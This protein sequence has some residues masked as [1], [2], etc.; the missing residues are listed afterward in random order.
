LRDITA[1]V[2]G[3]GFGSLLTVAASYY[4]YRGEGSS[5]VVFLLD[6]LLLGVAIV[7][8]RVSF[9]MMNLVTSTRNKKSRRVLVYGAGG[10]GRLLV[11]E[12]RA[13]A[14]WRMNPVGFIDDDPM[15]AHRWIVGVPVH[16]ALDQLERVM[17]KYS[18]DEVLLSSPAINGSVEHRIREVCAQL[19]RPVRR[20]RMEIN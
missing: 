9:Q 2:R 15:K 18:V 1:V 4:L 3:V 7:L 6:A 12:M 20:L 13:N 14:R 8:T 11:R 5:R 17:R 16:G 19:E 10:Y